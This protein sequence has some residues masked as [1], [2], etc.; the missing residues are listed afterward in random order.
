MVVPGWRDSSP[1]NHGVEIPADGIHDEYLYRRFKASAS[2]LDPE[3][4]HVVKLSKNPF[5][6][7]SSVGDSTGRQRALLGTYYLYPHR[8]A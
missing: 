8:R 1:L 7:V 3:A 5:D 6:D 2:G 4:V